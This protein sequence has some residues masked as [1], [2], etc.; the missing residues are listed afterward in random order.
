MSN[1]KIDRNMKKLAPFALLLTILITSCNTQK[2]IVQDDVYN[3]AVQKPAIVAPEKDY[4]EELYT[5]DYY[6][7]EY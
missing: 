4:E 3:N 2:S 7:P 6:D 5:E 1:Q